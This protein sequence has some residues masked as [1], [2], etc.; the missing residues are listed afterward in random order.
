MRAYVGRFAPSPT[1]PLHYGSLVA[2]VA[3]YLQAASQAGTWLVRMDDLDPPREQAGASDS[4]LQALDIH[5]FEYPA[6]VYQ[7]NRLDR[8]TEVLE[9]LLSS[10]VAYP[11]ACSRKQ[12]HATASFGRAG[13]IYPGTCRGGLPPGVTNPLAVRLRTDNQEVQFSDGLQGPQTCRI[14]SEI[15]DFL[16][17]RGDGLI[18]YHLAAVI[19][20][21]EQAVTEVVRGTDLLDSSFPQVFLQRALGLP[22]PA[23][24]HIPVVLNARGQ[25]LSKQTHAAPINQEYP[26]RNIFKC[27]LFL[28]QNPPS[29]LQSAKL[30]ELWAWARQHWN[31]ARLAGQRSRPETAI[32][33]Q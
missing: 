2:A 28:E 8:Y 3:S 25:K 4:I 9:Q 16:L 15:G 21:A 12:I 14:E 20:D 32:M 27:L 5:G 13:A 31:P 26:V 19:D 33:M 30:D 29:S 11:C 6:P 1:G 7:S 23:Y 22:Q 10:G 24:M 17:R 18:S